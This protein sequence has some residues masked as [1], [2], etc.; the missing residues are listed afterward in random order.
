MI[1]E[2]KIREALEELR[3]ELARMDDRRSV[4][5]SLVR[6]YETLLRIEGKEIVRPGLSPLPVEPPK[7]TPTDAPSFRGS[8]LKVLRDA[9]GEPLQVKELYRRVHE[10]GATTTS[11]HPLSV[12]A[13]NII[14]LSE[15]HPIEKTAPRTWRWTGE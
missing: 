9:Q 10:L 12:V 13:L 4:L 3:A 7:P 1:E 15:S 11:K 5:Q 6:N 14:S 2:T 8:V